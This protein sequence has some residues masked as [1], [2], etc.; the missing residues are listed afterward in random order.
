M[1]SSCGRLETSIRV[2][3]QMYIKDVVTWTS[4]ISAYGTCGEGEKA[5]RAFEEMEATGV[6]PDHLAFLAV[7]Y[8]CSHSGLVEDGLAY[9]DRMKKHYKVEPRMEHY[10]CVVDLL[11]R[12]GLL[13]QA[14]DFIHTMPMKADASIWGSLLSA[15]RENGEEKIAAHV[16][17]Q[18]VQLNSYDTGYHILVSNVYA[19]LGKWDKV[20][21]MR[22]YMKAKGL[23]KDPEFSWM[24]IQKKG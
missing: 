21:M 15:C 5:L 3:E 12:S 16:S 23:T 4:L 13:A 19:A 8:A 11:S 1:Y 6:L 10:A 14:E 24:E 17:E 2:F 7:I 22:K 18:I 9:F 20:R